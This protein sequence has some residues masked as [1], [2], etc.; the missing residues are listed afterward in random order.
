MRSKRNN[1]LNKKR[2]LRRKSSMKK[3]FGGSSRSS[4]IGYGDPANPAN[5]RRQIQQI[6]E[7]AEIQAQLKQVRNNSNLAIELSKRDIQ[8]EARQQAYLAQQQAQIRASQQQKE[9]LKANFINSN[10]QYNELLSQLLN[11]TPTSNII[12]QAQ[13]RASQQQKEL[14]NAN[15]INNKKEYNEL[16]SQL[17]NVTPE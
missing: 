16:L 14:L 15:F 2:N 1:R 12:Q 6:I 10:N 7:N 13:I 4:G 11:V 8:E 17:L 9:L 3:H 5:L